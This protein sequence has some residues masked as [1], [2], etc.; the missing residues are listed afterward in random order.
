MFE[1]PGQRHD[2][3]LMQPK[4]LFMH[5][6]NYEMSSKALQ[7][8]YCCTHEIRSENAFDRLCPWQTQDNNSCHLVFMLFTPYMQLQ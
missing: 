7:L 5:V 6:F 4:L 1:L 8:E 3:L 2:I